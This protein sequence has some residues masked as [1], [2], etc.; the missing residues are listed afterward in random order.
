M[1]YPV[2]F[3]RQGWNDL[4]DWIL[5]LSAEHEQECRDQGFKHMREFPLP[6]DVAEPVSSVAEI[7]QLPHN[8]AAPKRRGRPPRV[9]HDDS[10]ATD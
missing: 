8:E 3:Y 6:D 9:K 1:E 2:T 7:Q 10:G 4:S 5:V